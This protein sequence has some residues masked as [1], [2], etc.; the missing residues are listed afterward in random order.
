M[1]KADLKKLWVRFQTS[2]Y[3]RDDEDDVKVSSFYIRISQGQLAC[4]TRTS[5]NT[6]LELHNIEMLE[7]EA[8]EKLYDEYDVTVV[9]SDSGETYL[10]CRAVV[11][12]EV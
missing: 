3:N 6:P 4:Y 2:T 5:N 7:K 12:D 8:E 9:E 1:K 11:E 10:R